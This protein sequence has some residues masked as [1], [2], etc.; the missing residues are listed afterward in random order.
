MATIHGVGVTPFS[1]L[2]NWPDTV[3]AQLLAHFQ[4]QFQYQFQFQ[5][6][7]Q[8]QRSA[9]SLCEPF[10]TMSAIALNA[11]PT[12][13]LDGR[14]RARSVGLIN[15]EGVTNTA[16]SLYIYV[17]TYMGMC[18]H[19]YIQVCAFV[20]VCALAVH[21][22]RC[23]KRLHYVLNAHGFLRLAGDIWR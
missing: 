2:T 17:R 14:C 3:P 21:C 1:T 15:C 19:M 22:C 8:F 23:S 12:A 7:F 13:L 10:C 16:L 20:C 11:A 9:R 5:F 6:Q 4:F 18:I